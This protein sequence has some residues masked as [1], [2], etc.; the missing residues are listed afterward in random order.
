VSA[1]GQAFP[2]RESRHIRFVGWV[3]TEKLTPG[4]YTVLAVLPNYQ[5]RPNPELTAD[6][7]LLPP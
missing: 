6:F 5:T 4:R 1:G 3:D 7:E 2:D